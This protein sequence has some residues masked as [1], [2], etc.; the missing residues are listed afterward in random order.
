[1]TPETTIVIRAFN[2]AL[3]LPK[4]LDT[5]RSQNYRALEV[6]VV[7][8]GSFDGT[9]EIAMA[10]GASV[11]KL[12]PDQF[13]FGYSLNLGIRHAR[14]R[15]I[16]VVSAHTCPTDAEWLGTLVEPL[17]DPSV[18]MV[19]GRQ[20]ATQESKFSEAQDFRRA[21]GTEPQVLRPPNYFA[22]NANSAFRRELWDAYQFD[23]ALP[24]LEDAEWA[25]AWMGRG[26]RVIY[27]PRAAIYHIHNE[28]WRQ[29]RHR[30]YREAVAAARI[31]V[32]RRRTA[33]KEIAR[34]IGWT[35]QDLAI[36]SLNPNGAGRAARW[37]EILSFRFQKSLGT[38]SG[39]LDGRAL[40]SRQ[41]REQYFFDKTFSAVVVEGPGKA[42]LQ[43]V[44]MPQVR[45]SD[46]V[47]RVAYVGVCGTDLEIRDGTLGYFK[48]GLGQ[49]P[50]VPGHEMSGRVVALGSKINDLD[51]GDSVVVECI[52]SCGTCEECRRENFIGCNER[53]ELGV[54]R[55]NGAY[56]E[57]V[58]VPRRFVH[59]V[60]ADLPLTKA[61]LC[62]PLAVVI[63]G[64]RRIDHVLK[65]DRQCVVVGGG[66]LGRLCA[67]VL[68]H[69]GHR[70]ALVDQHPTR[71]EGLPGEVETSRVLP[72]L[73][74]CDVVIEATGNADILNEVLRKSRAGSTVLILGFPYGDRNFSFEQLVGYDK[75]VIGSVGSTAKD[76]QDAIA[77]LP[78]LNL[79]SYCDNVFP[80]ADF[81]QVWDRF[82]KR[83][84]LKALLKP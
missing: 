13:T 63:K 18:A 49:Y 23:P 2:E 39:L 40:D 31:G 58:V 52:Q 33:A 42:S 82:S 70:V 51:E 45:P 79:G 48:S 65:N 9:R 76:F 29:V 60:P 44:R 1:M 43:Q 84:L 37:S 21:F 30:Y 69:H 74:K 26:L 4:L 12:E 15:F 22:N 32:K 64:F 46:V 71:L 56:A 27:E 83:E 28:T 17:R 73:S 19:Y 57:Y 16:A 77:L 54:L 53:R 35:L 24:G 61:A 41:G 50:I 75:S 6:I 67:L 34:E 59:R 38:V 7:D 47:V 20:L 11:I 25:K 68:H 55:T 78:D 72:D 62:E 5:I 36:A 8:S 80:L 81:Q 14:G 3:H 66:P 10:W